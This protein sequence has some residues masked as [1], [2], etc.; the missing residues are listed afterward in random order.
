MN[1]RGE[2]LFR[3]FI[4]LYITLYR[5]IMLYIYFCIL[6]GI[7]YY[8]DILLYF[9]GLETYYVIVIIFDASLRLDGFTNNF[10]LQK[11]AE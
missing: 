11:F 8:S 9:Y 3:Y 5:I 6:K 1:F 4:V 2:I 10:E 7:V